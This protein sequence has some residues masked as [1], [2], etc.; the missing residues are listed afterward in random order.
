ME[1]RNVGT[2]STFAASGQTRIPFRCRYQILGYL[3]TKFVSS[4]K[5]LIDNLM[6]MTL[7]QVELKKDKFEYPG[8]S[9]LKPLSGNSGPSKIHGGEKLQRLLNQAF[10]P[11]KEALDRDFERTH[12]ISRYRETRVAK[13]RRLRIRKTF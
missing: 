7:K 8:K 4:L 11:K 3:K 13:V 5:L 2:K 1:F 10:Q 6:E 9:R 12:Q